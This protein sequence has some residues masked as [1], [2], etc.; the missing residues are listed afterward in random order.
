MAQRIDLRIVFHE[1]SY[2]SQSIKDVPCVPRAGDFIH[3]DHGSAQIMHVVYDFG[4][5]TATVATLT[6]DVN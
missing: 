2:M 5:D 6:V 3:T 4:G 1:S